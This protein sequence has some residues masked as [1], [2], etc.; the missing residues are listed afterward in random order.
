MSS[1][2]TATGM[3]DELSAF[4]RS[5]YPASFF[6]KPSPRPSPPSADSPPRQNKP[7][8]FVTLTYAQSADGKIAGPGG[9]Q[10]RLSGDESM[11][12]THKLVAALGLGRSS[13]R[14]SGSGER[15][16]DQAPT[17][18]ERLREIHDSILVGI[19][20][21]LADDPQLNGQSAVWSCPS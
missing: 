8:P 1:T 10:V 4:L 5:F 15:R 6:D 17:F 12:L 18:I 16:A 11:L 21:V 9:S 14:G 20:T 19:G 2:A 13:E 3:P 7:K